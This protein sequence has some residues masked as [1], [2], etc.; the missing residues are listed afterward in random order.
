MFI[1]VAVIG[2]F[3]VEGV[4]GVQGVP[5]VI[6]VLGVVAVIGVLGVVAVILF[7]SCS[8]TWR[9]WSHSSKIGAGRYYY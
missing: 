9:F 6:G 3:E 5:A 8:G 2:V 4:I 1:F 7:G